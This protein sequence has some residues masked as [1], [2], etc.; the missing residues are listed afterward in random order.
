LAAVSPHRQ[1]A[2]RAALKRADLDALEPIGE[3]TENPMERIPVEHEPAR[4]G[5][6]RIDVFLEERCE[7]YSFAACRGGIGH[8]H[9][10][11]PVLRTA[12]QE[13]PHADVLTACEK[14]I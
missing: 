1:R 10:F 7:R 6:D 4:L 5:T 3:L 11:R 13:L 12:M 8:G 9:A 2:V 14:R